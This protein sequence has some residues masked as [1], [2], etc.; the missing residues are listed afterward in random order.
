MRWSWTVM[1]GAVSVCWAGWCR[2]GVHH[3]REAKFRIAVSVNVPDGPRNATTG[4]V[5]LGA[6][7]LVVSCEWSLFIT[8]ACVVVV[9]VNSKPRVLLAGLLPAWGGCA[10][11]VL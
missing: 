3:P 2:G 9:M 1:D 11:Y 5:W 8:P 7:S 4:V 10:V 6:G